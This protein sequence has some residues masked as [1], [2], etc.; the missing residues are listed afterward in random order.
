M[1]ACLIGIEYCV[2]EIEVPTAQILTNH[3]MHGRTGGPF[4][5]LLAS[6][7]PVPRDFCRYPIE[8]AP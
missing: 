6:L 2:C 7:L 4:S 5:R 1:T 3:E 8:I